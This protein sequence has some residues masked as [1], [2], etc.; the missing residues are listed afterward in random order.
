M[1]TQHIW[2]SPEHV[3]LPASTWNDSLTKR[4]FVIHLPINFI[5]LCN[6]LQIE[7]AL[8]ILCLV[9]MYDTI[10][11]FYDKFSICNI[12]FRIFNSL[13]TT[14]NG[15][16]LLLYNWHHAEIDHFQKS[17]H[18]G[19]FV[20]RQKP[21]RP[22]WEKKRL[23]TTELLRICY[24]SFPWHRSYKSFSMKSHN[25]WVIWKFL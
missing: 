14:W 20:L 19:F 25:V 3:L 4:F 11:F 8:M 18:R 5:W 24:C 15:K 2:F 22:T 23:K 10:I 6:H 17:N 7:H 13:R 12:K 16:L 1:F 21:L 9:S